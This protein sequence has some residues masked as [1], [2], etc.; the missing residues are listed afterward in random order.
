MKI[1]ES[2]T[3][4]IHLDAEEAYK[5][6]R[7]LEFVNDKIKMRQYGDNISFA[8]IAGRYKNSDIIIKIIK[9]LSDVDNN[10]FT[11]RIEFANRDQVFIEFEGF[12]HYFEIDQY[13][14]TSKMFTDGY[15]YDMFI[16]RIKSAID[17]ISNTN[18]DKQELSNDDYIK[19][20]DMLHINT[21][22]SDTEFVF[23]SVSDDHES[24]KVLFT[25]CWLKFNQ[26]SLNEEDKK[27]FTI[28]AE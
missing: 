10:D 16:D 20:S 24:A 15:K 12:I 1:Y 28:K 9:K 13:G 5:I 22:T 6:F 3:T 8:K 23:N 4:I 19:L 25:N 7:T 27:V 17:I 21:D 14:I 2:K 18:N 26:E 11:I